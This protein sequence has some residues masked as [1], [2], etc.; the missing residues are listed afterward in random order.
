MLRPNV[1]DELRHRLTI[2]SS[3]PYSQER[4]SPP[5]PAARSARAGMTIRAPDTHPGSP[6]GPNHLTLSSNSV[7]ALTLTPELHLSDGE[8][9][10]RQLAPDMRNDRN[11]GETFL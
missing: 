10:G 11:A 1:R 5:L 4:T 9:R 2:G 3:P 6:S 7:Q 8:W